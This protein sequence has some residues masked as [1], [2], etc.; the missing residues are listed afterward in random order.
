MQMRM[1][2]GMPWM[3]GRLLGFEKERG[4]GGGACRGEGIVTT[5]DSTD[6][7]DPLTSFYRSIYGITPIR[8]G[9]YDTKRHAGVD[10]KKK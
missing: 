3:R 9:V 4:H 6:I 5:L 2:R 7:F 1:R 10:L 8:S